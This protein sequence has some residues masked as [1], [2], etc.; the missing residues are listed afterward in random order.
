MTC[1]LGCHSWI[2][3]VSPKQVEDCCSLGLC[4]RFLDIPQVALGFG[5]SA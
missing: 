2:H 1:P 5:V 3:V 4:A